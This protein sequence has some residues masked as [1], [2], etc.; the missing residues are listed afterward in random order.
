MELFI[1]TLN[2]SKSEKVSVIIHS[3]HSHN[4]EIGEEFGV[5]SPI[6]LKHVVCF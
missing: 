6:I 4:H 2:L 3:H 1:Y 5:K